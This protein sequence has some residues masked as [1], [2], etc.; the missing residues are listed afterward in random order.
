VIAFRCDGD[1]R[2][3]AGHVARC[4][5]LARAFEAAGEAVLMCGIYQGIAADLV[6]DLPTAPAAIPDEA[7]AV[8]V[9]SYEIPAARIESLARRLPVAVVEDGAAA[10]AVTAVLAY[11]LDATERTA[12][13]EGTVAVL[14]P[15][16]APIRP[17]C[18]CARRARGLDQGLV[19]VGG[20]SAGEHLISAA[21]DALGEVVADVCVVCPGRAVAPDEMLELIAAADVA[22]SAAGSTPYELACAGV[23]SVLVA[24]ADNQLPIAREFDRAGV[25][26]GLGDLTGLSD[27]VAR[28][29]DP[30][31]RERLAT[32][33]PATVDGYGA[34]RARDALLAAFAGRRPPPPLRYRP[35]TA[36]DLEL[37]LAW[38]NDPEVR[39]VSRSTDAVSR[40]EH[41]RWLAGV[42]GDSNRTL[43]VVEDG[44]EPVG[45]IRFDRDGERS[46]ISV[47]V[48]PG[49]RGGG[50]GS[51]VIREAAEL[52]LAGRPWLR[53]VVAE[54]RE[55]NVRS[56]RAFEKAGY[57]RLRGRPSEGSLQLA[58]D[59]TALPRATSLALAQTYD[60]GAAP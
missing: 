60:S 20:G 49:R 47:T 21:A 2:V 15:D 24:V 12:I 1:D 5:Q 3:G 27:A 7:G 35:A 28:L 46:E 59:R 26:L 25:A 36:G 22:V 52:E 31:L 13:P 8:V 10:P 33:G 54:V 50:V 56:L 14:G 9:D 32:A 44:A 16:Y 58:L 41:E 30:A 42:L 53:E 17:G 18:V 55:R 11:H 37:L 57:R 40:E 51:R 48:A 34:F 6:G 29:V 4:V 38:R 23:P 39:E 19:T 45:T 43:L